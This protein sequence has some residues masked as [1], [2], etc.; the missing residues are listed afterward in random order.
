MSFLDSNQDSESAFLIEFRFE[1][2]AT[3]V[4][5]YGTLCWKWARG[6]SQL[7]MELVRQGQHTFPRSFIERKKAP[8][9]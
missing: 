2:L 6:T 7:S 9:S 5:Y 4:L 3:V 8:L 1:T